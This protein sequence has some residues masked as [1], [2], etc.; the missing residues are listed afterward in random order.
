MAS[1]TITLPTT[2]SNAQ[3][4]VL[5]SVF[6]GKCGRL[7]PSDE[8]VLVP[9]SQ[10]PEGAVERWAL[11]ESCHEDAYWLLYDGH[12]YNN[13]CFCCLCEMMMCGSGGNLKGHMAR[14]SSRLRVLTEE[15][16]GKAYLLFLVRHNLPFSTARD[17][18]LRMMCPTVTYGRLL[19]LLQTT[20]QRIKR[21]ITTEAHGKLLSL[22][23]DGWSDMSLRRFLGIAVSIFDPASRCHCYRF[24]G[25]YHTLDGHSAESQEKVVRDCLQEYELRPEKLVSFCSDSAS[26]NTSL[27]DRVSFTWIPCCCHLWNLVVRHFLDNSPERLKKILGNINSL[28]SKTLWVEFLARNGSSVRNLSIYVPTRWC[29]VCSCLRSFCM[30]REHIV[31]FQSLSKLN[32]FTDEDFLLVDGVIDLLVRFEE[33]NLMLMAADNA[34]G[35][36]TVYEGINGIYT[37]LEPFE[38]N[39]GLFQ[40]ACTMAR[41]EIEWRFFRCES[42]FCC[43]L[44]FAGVLNVAHTIPPFLQSIL[45][46]VLSIMASEVESLTSA[47]PPSSPSAHSPAARFSHLRPLQESIDD[48]PCSSEQNHEVVEEISSFMG[49]RSHLPKQKFSVFWW[50]CKSF[51]RLRMLAMK[52]RSI[53]TNTSRLEATFSLAR[54]ILSWNR[55]R[56]SPT[57]SSQLC[58]LVANPSLTESLLGLDVHC[59]I[60]PNESDTR[61]WSLDDEID[62][63]ISDEEE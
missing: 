33:L 36:A 56:L 6:T 3:D 41:R 24:L 16:Q 15:D 18:V 2:P 52:L 59:D 43:R 63:C 27:A 4:S 42:R 17:P 23:V 5:L 1:R 50:S 25:L 55:M 38:L 20:A 54:R 34:E 51:P 49:K 47:T 7:Q 13:L 12:R 46:P 53:P 45:N 21:A 40:H 28:R 39:P 57:H 26:V 61:Q 62:E 48:S 11:Q 8:T 14:H 10:L 9:L 35:L 29:S 30:L 32:G 58:L 19:A 60:M 31:A 37:V 44:L 22:M